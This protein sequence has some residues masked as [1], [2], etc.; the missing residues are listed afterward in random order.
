VR[1]G[2]IVLLLAL[3]FAS[4]S[5]RAQRANPDVVVRTSLKPESG[6]VIGQHVALFVDVLFRGEMPR[7]PRVT[8]PDMPGAQAF[9]FETQATTMSDTVNGE[10]YTGQRFE[11]AV[12]PRRG[13]ELVIPPAVATLLDKAGDEMGTAKGEAVPTQVSVPVGVDPSQPVIATSNLTLD[14]QWAPNPT[15][16]FTAGDALVRILTR[17]AEEVPSLAMRDLAF[18]APE[19]VRVYRDTP[20]SEDKIDR[21]AL[22]GRRV[23]RVTYVF[24]TAGTF[25][26]PA[27]SQPWWD[28]GAGR[29]QTAEGKS[30]SVSVSAAPAA[31][32]NGTS[33]RDAAF[34]R[35]PSNWLKPV[36]LLAGIAVGLWGIARGARWSWAAWAEHRRRWRQSEACAFDNLIAVCRDGDLRAI[37]R[38]FAFWRSRLPAAA[39]ASAV[40]L[41]AEIEG[42]L[43]GIGDGAA[44]WAPDRCQALVQTLRA[45]R[46][47]LLRPAPRSAKSGLPPLNPPQPA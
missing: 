46:P 2:S 8:I 32:P 1:R 40:T 43:F 45:A 25:R 16:A 10:S 3:A 23:E 31:A 17:T 34:W 11:F 12:Y 41:A 33:L 47:A 20:E 27:I 4:P 30:V 26:L 28:L 13:G 38:A 29:L 15:T 9:R 5:A 42:G 24:E 19:G 22:T 44:K 7:P 21:G 35:D 18:P 6:A 37:Y 39:A 36:S 14:E